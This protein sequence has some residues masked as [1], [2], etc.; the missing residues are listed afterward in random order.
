MNT[1]HLLEMD[2]II[3]GGNSP[4]IWYIKTFLCDFLIDSTVASI[5]QPLISQPVV[6]DTSVPCLNTETQYPTQC[7]TLTHTFL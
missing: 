4:G 6:S 2:R 1:V 7:S 5:L 3:K